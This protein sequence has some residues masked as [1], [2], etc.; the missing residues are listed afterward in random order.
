MT[1][2]RLLFWGPVLSASGY[3]EHA[4]QLLRALM[5][6]GRFDID[7]HSVKWG[8]TPF[9]DEDPSDTF[10]TRVRQLAS[11]KPRPGHDVAVQVTIPNEF[12]RMAPLHIGVTA[13]IEVDRVSPIWIEKC[14]SEVDVVVVP[15]FHSARAFSLTYRAQDGRELKLHTPLAV[16]PEGVDVEAFFPSPGH[17]SVLPTDLPAKN[18]LSVGLGMDRP[19]GE[20]RKNIT[21]LVR[22]FCEAFAGRDDVGLILKTSIVNYSLMD[23]EAVLSKIAA[24]KEA[25]NLRLPRITLIHGRLSPTQLASVYNDERV[26]S[27]VT[28]THGEGF[29]LPTLEAAACG[30]PIIA[31]DWSGHLDF[32]TVNDRKLF[33]PVKVEMREIPASA[34]WNGVMDPGTRWA[35]PDAASAKALMQKMA[36]EPTA[37]R[38]WARELATHVRQHYSVSATGTR[39]VEFVNSL[40]SQGPSVTAPAVPAGKKTLIFTMPMSA[41]D[42]LLSTSVVRKLRKKFP[43]HHLIYATSPQFKPILEGNPDID[44]VID[45]QEW[46]L[47]V[48][49]LELTYDEVYTPNT[50]IQLVTSNWVHGGR[51]R[52]ILDE[53]ANLCGVTVNREDQS[54][55]PPEKAFLELP[56]QYI[57]IHAGSGGGKWSARNYRRWPA[58]VKNLKRLLPDVRLV[59][60]GGKDDRT[61]PE[62]LDLRGRTDV[63]QLVNVMRRATCV[64]CID[65]FP[66]HVAAAL[67]TPVVSLFGGSYVNSTGPRAGPRGCSSRALETPDRMGCAKACYKDRCR[68]DAD[69]PCINNIHPSNVVK[70][71]LDAMAL[72][73]EGITF[74]DVRPRLVGYTHVLN[75]ERSGYPYLQSISSMLGFC[76]EVLVV[77]GGS[78]DGSVERIKALGKNVKVVVRKW[79][80]LEPGMDGMQKAFGRAMADARPED[81]LWQQDAD[82][83]VH[84]RDYEKIRAL[85]ERFPEDVSVLSLPVVELW[86]SDKR[87][88]TDRHSWK[89]RL[90]RNDFRITHGINRGA[91]LTDEKTGKTYARRG[92]S[93]GCELIDVMTGEFISHRNF[94]TQELEDLRV[95]DPEE[96]GRRM[97]ETFGKLPSVFHYSWVDLE[98][99]VRNF[100]DFW[101][102]Q[103]SRLHGDV[104]PAPRF[105]DVKTDEDVV[106]K[107]VELRERGGEHGSAPTF[108]LAVEPPSLALPPSPPTPV[109][110]TPLAKALVAGGQRPES[111]P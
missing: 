27:Y 32:L 85:L 59:A 103:W 104:E 77:D 29:G 4:R 35:E 70:N 102:V 5:D 6:D 106:R 13:G 21:R 60:V 94:Y 72:E 49:R 55:L 31:T 57:V 18:F 96:Y 46:M 76:D 64:V 48:P 23:R 41:G 84:P 34:V 9:L 78:D 107:A 68:V 67:G 56:S 3:G 83:V 51:G 79:D 100:R 14:N 75:P 36:N 87:V 16:I 44:D 45:W 33:A 109:G 7:V 53:M 65:S 63:G 19:E 40:A 95:H 47:D 62:C 1:K 22:H 24:V 66:M 98:R 25:L 105:P 10:L 61:F 69:R 73:A 11:R 110:D 71:V 111:S 108:E 2:R 43:E 91:R 12:K 99:K 101:D 80:P 89:W 30:L 50:G 54:V 38:E 82:E 15:S 86:G 90:T 92:M 81:F 74:E 39:F 26:V 52:H 17:S 42:V 28:L 97:N 88:R 37:P 93:D 8:S 58:V 20:D